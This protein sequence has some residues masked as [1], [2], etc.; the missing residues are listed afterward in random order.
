M[1]PLTLLGIALTPLLLSGCIVLDQVTTLAVHPDGSADLV[2]FHSNVRSTE[3]GGKAEEELRRHAAAFD[4]GSSDELTRIRN[5]GGELIEARWLRREPPYST[6]TVARFHNAEALE[7]LGTFQDD[8]GELRVST[9]F[10]QD[11][12]RRK[13]TM[14][15]LPP[16]D[17]N[18]SNIA[19]PSP[20]EAR[21]NQ[22]NGLNE[23][24]VIVVGGR[25]VAARGW[26]V[27]DDQ[28]S[29]L[30]AIEEIRRLLRD[31]PGRIELFIEWEMPAT[32]P[33]G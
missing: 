12:P 25:I 2:V 26:T 3:E 13:L 33:P 1:R 15:V 23:T 10:S 17:L 4:G 27:S 11:G 28:R 22:V 6:V 14:V 8:D 19:E 30:L 9:R 16:K 24:R 31:S 20:K 29:A 18:L 7:K 21:Q 5:A 32:P